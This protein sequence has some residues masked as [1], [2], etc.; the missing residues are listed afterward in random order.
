[1]NHSKRTQALIAQ[2]KQRTMF[3]RL[4]MAFCLIVALAA[5]LSFGPVWLVADATRMQ[6]ETAVLRVLVDDELTANQ[7]LMI[8]VAVLKSNDRLA[9]IAKKDLGMIEPPTARTWVSLD[10]PLAPE[11]TI[12][13]EQPADLWGRI[14]RLA[15]G[16]ASALLVGDV[17]ITPLR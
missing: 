3:V 8:D 16:E 13:S 14:A 12:P 4:L 5:A 10:E 9:H 1:M 15:I 11:P 7:R 6:Q 17:A 2:G